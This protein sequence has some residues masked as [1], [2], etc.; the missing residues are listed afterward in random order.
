LGSFS[1]SSG[2]LGNTSGQ[3]TGIQITPEFRSNAERISVK[4][5]RTLGQ[6]VR[7]HT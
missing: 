2:R 4:T 5:V 3:Y 7:T 6:A 1:I